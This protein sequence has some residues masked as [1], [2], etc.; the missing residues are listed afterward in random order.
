MDT[1]KLQGR[2]ALIADAVRRSHT[3]LTERAFLR[4]GTAAIDIRF[5]SVLNLVFAGR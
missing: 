3:A 4:A 1:R 2:V 5:V